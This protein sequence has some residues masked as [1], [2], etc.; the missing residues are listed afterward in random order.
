MK[1]KAIFVKQDTSKLEQALNNGWE[2]SHVAANEHGFVYML[3]KQ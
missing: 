1:Y 3:K 2:L